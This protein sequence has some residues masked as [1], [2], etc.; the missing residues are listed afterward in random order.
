[1]LVLF[2]RIL[3]KMRVFSDEIIAIKNE[4]AS[5]AFYKILKC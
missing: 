1:M 3:D 5:V 2:L 4:F